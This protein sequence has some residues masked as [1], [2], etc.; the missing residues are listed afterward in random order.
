MVTGYDMENDELIYNDSIRYKKLFNTGGDFTGKTTY[1]GN[2]LNFKRSGD[3]YT[4]TAVNNNEGDIKEKDLD[5]FFNPYNMVANG[6]NRVSYTNNFWPLDEIASDEGKDFIF[7]DIDHYGTS[8][9][10]K[11]FIARDILGTPAATAGKEYIANAFSGNSKYYSYEAG[12]Y[13]VSSGPLPVSDDKLNHNSYFGM[14]YGVNFSLTEDYVGPLNYYFYGDDDLWVFLDGKLVCDLGGVHS[15]IGCYVDLWDWISDEEK[16]GTHNLTFFYLE[17]G[18]SGSSCFMQFTLPSVAPASLN[19][20]DTGS[21]SITKELSGAVTESEEEFTYTLDV[22]DTDGN[23][24]DDYFN[25]IRT[26]ATGSESNVINGNGGIFTL[27]AGDIINISGIPKNFTYSLTETGGNYVTEWTTVVGDGESESSGSNAQEQSGYTI[28]GTITGGKT[29]TITCINTYKLNLNITKK[30]EGD[31]AEK[32]DNTYKFAVSLKDAD[33]NA[34]TT[35]EYN[36]TL[37]GAV[38]T[39]TFNNDGQLEFMLKANET[40]VINGIHPDAQWKVTEV[41]HDGFHVTYQIGENGEVMRSDS[42]GE[43]KFTDGDTVIFTNYTTYRLPDTGGIGTGFYIIGG[44]VATLA[45]G[46]F[47]KYNLKKRKREEKVSFKHFES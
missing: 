25:F 27:K 13:P 32:A 17:R 34:I 40:A 14:Q 7:G 45:L 47:L 8:V 43:N 39:F 37:A 4:L 19:P 3:T 10:A 36:G 38:H 35:G 21:V 18:A 1:A 20:E 15:S 31:A 12:D 29:H 2:E 30:V 24:V 11:R 23:T 46:I 28:T 26:T 44:L 5:K 22:K 6:T 16:A 9:K 41:D 33:G 42:T